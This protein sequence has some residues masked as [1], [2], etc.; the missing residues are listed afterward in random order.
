LSPL[1]RWPRRIAVDDRLVAAHG[2]S[3]VP[4]Q[5]WDGSR[6][7][8]RICRPLYAGLSAHSA[9]IEFGLLRHDG[10]LWVET[11]KNYGTLEELERVEQVYRRTIGAAVDGA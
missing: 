7:S 2:R 4:P 3:R 11:F 8:G 6:L 5:Q 10:S 1:A 9:E